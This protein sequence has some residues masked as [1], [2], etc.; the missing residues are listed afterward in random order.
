MIQFDIKA[1][2]VILNGVYGMKDLNRDLLSYVSF[3]AT[4]KPLA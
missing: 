1:S 4:S 3:D 2:C